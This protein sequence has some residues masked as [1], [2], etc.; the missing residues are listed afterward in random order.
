MRV[1]YYSPCL[2]S[3]SSTVFILSTRWHHIT[4]V[5][6][7]LSSITIALG[8]QVSPEVTNQE[9]ISL[10]GNDHYLE[11]PI[12]PA[13]LSRTHCMQFLQVGLRPNV[14]IIISIKKACVHSNI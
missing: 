3:S 11:N 5:P 6:Q 13:T 12:D 10:G 2:K 14:S 7:A 9:E 1:V 4:T 8:A